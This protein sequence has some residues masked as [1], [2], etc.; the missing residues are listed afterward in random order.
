[1]WFK[2]FHNDQ[3]HNW[4]MH[5]SANLSVRLPFSIL[6]ELVF[7]WLPEMPHVSLLS[8]RESSRGCFSSFV[9]LFATEKKWTWYN[10]VPIISDGSDSLNGTA[11][12]CYPCKYHLPLHI[13]EGNVSSDTRSGGKIS[14]NKMYRVFHAT[15]VFT[16]MQIEITCEAVCRTFENCDSYC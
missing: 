7:L 14:A 4:R 5:L 2:Y 15:S 9:C 8:C 12:I 16:A 3:S 6:P 11:V 10:N 1:M 13:C